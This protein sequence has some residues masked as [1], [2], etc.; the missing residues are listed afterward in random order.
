[1]ISISIFIISLGGLIGLI[2]FSLWEKKR[3]SKVGARYREV[4][5]QATRTGVEKLVKQIPVVDAHLFR[6]LYHNS[7]HLTALVVLRL[8]KVVEKRAVGVLNTVRGKRELSKTDTQ[9][10]FLKHVSDHKQGLEK[11]TVGPVE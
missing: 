8:V 4:L 2:G 11:T 6:R 7:A 10:T 3:E 1:M 5:D 9:S